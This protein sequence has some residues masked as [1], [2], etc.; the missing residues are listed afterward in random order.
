M[1]SQRRNFFLPY[2]HLALLKKHKFCGHRFVIKPTVLNFPGCGCFKALISKTT[3]WS[4]TQL[5]VLIVTMLKH[6]FLNSK[7]DKIPKLN[8]QANYVRAKLFILFI[9]FFSF[10]RLRLHALSHFLCILYIFTNRV[11]ISSLLIMM[12]RSHRKFKFPLSHWFLFEKKLL[13]KNVKDWDYCELYFSL[14]T[15]RNSFLIAMV[16]FLFRSIFSPL[17]SEVQHWCI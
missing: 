5:S 2:S 15:L 3:I 16:F 7:K 1:I 10:S 8:T 12:T 13:L 17:K 6:N 11:K 9:Y 14:R 4:P